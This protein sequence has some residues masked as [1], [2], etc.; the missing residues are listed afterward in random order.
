MIFAFILAIAF[1]IGI[2][3]LCS[4]LEAMILSTT[5]AEIEGLKKTYPKRGEK[6]EKHKL[7]LEETSSAILSLNTIANTLGATMVGGLAVQMWPQDSNI[8]LKVSSAMALA[9]LFFSEIIPKNVGVLYRPALQPI[10][11]FPLVWLCAVMAPLSTVVGF[12]VRFTLRPPSNTTDS[13]EE[14]LLLA[15]K[16]AKEGTLTANER[17]MINNA[18]SL[19]EL[20]VNQIMTPRTVAYVID[21]QES[22]TSLLKKSKTIP[23]AR[24][25]IYEEQTDNITGIVRRRDILGAMASGKQS[26]LIKDLAND[27]IFV[28]DNAAASD[29]LQT[30]LK[31]H[32]QLAI[33]VDEFGSMSGVITMEDVIEQIIGQEIFED[34]DPAVDMRELA[35]RR[36]FA[37]KR[38]HRRE[39]K[40]A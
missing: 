22:V 4:V 16:S 30:F 32:Q 8:L 38:K 33:A 40:T 14:I 37:E 24:I 5:T 1:T 20:L 36:Q 12:V 26:K 10:L 6:L 11:I 27:A 35:R 25:P 29:A 21:G 15:E 13:D 39:T 2:S 7:G 34:D 31:N 17:D 9:I 23:F 28:P 18:L 3:A 19:D